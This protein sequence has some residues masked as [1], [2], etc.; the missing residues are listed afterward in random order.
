MVVLFFSLFFVLF[1]V[2]LVRLYHVTAALLL[3]LSQPASHSQLLFLTL[4][5]GFVT[6]LCLAV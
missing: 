4:R 6:L 5:P 2:H 3:S 1:D